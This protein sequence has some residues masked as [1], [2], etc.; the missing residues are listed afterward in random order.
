MN[1]EQAANKPAKKPKTSQNRRKS[2]E[3]VLK[4]IYRGML[5]AGELNRLQRMPKTTLTTSKP[6]KFISSNYWRA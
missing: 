1:G 3:L 4:A 6:M 5:N 2:R